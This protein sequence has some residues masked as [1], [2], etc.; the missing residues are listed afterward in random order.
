MSSISVSEFRT[1]CFALLQSVERTRSTIR[2]TR[3]GKP[4]AEIHPP[5]KDAAEIERLRAEREARD[6]ELLNKLADQMNAEVEDT[7][8]Y[9]ARRLR[10]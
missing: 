6:L 8:L 2:I 7:M 4:L 1:H 10:S 5:P 9:D 3:Y